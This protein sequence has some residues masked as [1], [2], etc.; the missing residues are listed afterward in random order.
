MRHVARH[1][2]TILSALS[3]LLCVATSTCYIIS[4]FTDDRFG[5]HLLVRYRELWIAIE[6]NALVVG[7]VVGQFWYTDSFRPG[8]WRHEMP[9]WWIIA[10]SAALPAVWALTRRRSSVPG[11]CSTCGYDLRATPEKSGPLFDRCPECGAVPVSS[12]VREHSA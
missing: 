11:R 6:S 1:L 2:F 5:A 12:A 9:V 4:R 7:S 10:S 3:L 8:D